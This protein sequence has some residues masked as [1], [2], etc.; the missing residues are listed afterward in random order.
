MR[1]VKPPPPPAR[2]PG[3]DVTDEALMERFCQ[4]DSGAFDALFERQGWLAILWQYIP[5]ANVA[6]AIDLATRYAIAAV[7]ITLLSAWASR[8]LRNRTMVKVQREA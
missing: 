1:R 5:R 3:D 7:V 6:I 4:G 2:S 8:T